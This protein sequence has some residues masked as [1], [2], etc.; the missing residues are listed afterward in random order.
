MYTPIHPTRHPTNT[1]AAERDLPLADGGERLAPR[2]GRLPL[3]R[4]A[5]AD[6]DLGAADDRPTDRHTNSY[7]PTARHSIHP[8]KQP[9][10]TRHLRR[11]PAPALRAPRRPGRRR[12]RR[13]GR[14]GGPCARRRPP[15]PRQGP[16]LSPAAP[17]AGWVLAR[18]GRHARRLRPLP[19][20]HLGRGGPLGAP[21][22]G[23][24]PRQRRARRHPAA[25]QHDGARVGVVIVVEE[26]GEGQEGR[27]QRHQARPALGH[28]LRAAPAPRP[29]ALRPPR[30]ALH[31]P[32]R[33]GRWRG[34]RRGAPGR[35][36]GVP[37]RGH[38]RPH[39][40]R[41]EP[42]GAGGRGPGRPPALAPRAGGGA[43]G[44]ARAGGL[45]GCVGVV[46]VAAAA[47]AAGDVVHEPEG[48]GGGARDG[49]GARGGP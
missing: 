44:A 48:A 9:T 24:W 15:A 21:P 4:Y 25:R 29:Q 19:V 14:R 17:G 2:R 46:G 10:P 32:R 8:Q 45:S 18:A 12:R 31:G 40:G 23:L 22:P 41:P 43:A 5:L 13:R 37:S 11:R 27:R 49:G 38:P 28:L 39:P 42:G 34:R 36:G 6:I 30:R 47:A 1:A 26:Q 20:H 35:G 33:R 16:G 3:P 7:V